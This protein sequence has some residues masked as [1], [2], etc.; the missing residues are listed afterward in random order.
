M[1]EMVSRAAKHVFS[2]YL[3]RLPL[4][5][6]PSIVAHLLNCLVGFKLN[7]SPS[8]HH[9]IDDEFSTIEP[10]W[11]GLD[12]KTMQAEIVREVFK[13]YRYQLEEDWWNQCKCIVLLREVCLKMGFQ[14]KAREYNF[15]K[16]E[17]AVVNNSAKSKKTNGTNGTNGH[18][19]EDTTFY[20]DDILNVVPVVK[21]GPLKVWST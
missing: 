13:R 6:V 15:E 2:R 17:A 12:P 8:A 1:H 19:I 4:L 18:K 5:D 9:P 21:D 14:M 10:E 20:P 3:R 16:R 11:M 7:A